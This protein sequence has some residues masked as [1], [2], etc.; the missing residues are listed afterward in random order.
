MR[1]N[2][3][4]ISI[5]HAN[6][7]KCS[8]PVD[9]KMFESGLGG[10]FETYVVE[11]IIDCVENNRDHCLWADDEQGYRVIP[12]GP[13]RAI[14]GICMGTL[15]AMNMALRYP[16]TFTAVAGNFGLPSLNEFIFPYTEE[17]VPLLLQYFDNPDL[18][19]FV[20][21]RLNAIYPALDGEHF[22]DNDPELAGISG[23]SIA[24]RVLGLV[25]EKGL[26]P[27]NIDCTV[28]A[29]A[30]RL[31]PHKSA[32]QSSL[33]RLFGLDVGAA[34][35]GTR[36]IHDVDRLALGPDRREHP[37]YLLLD[38]VAGNHDRNHAPPIL[39]C[40]AAAKALPLDG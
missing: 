21:E 19:E 27:A 12:A 17:V 1:K 14:H 24:S 20:D 4:L 28:I 35:L 7:P 30:P 18:Q 5:C 22:P 3:L 9:F 40:V 37:D 11:D 6:C 25:A 33:A 15:G 26:R 2:R 31:G 8:L 32:M 39:A 16:S 38:P 34:S 13:S 10:D 36:V 29:E 23:A